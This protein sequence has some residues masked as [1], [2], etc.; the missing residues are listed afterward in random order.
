MSQSLA[1]AFLVGRQGGQG[2]HRLSWGRL[3]WGNCGG[4]AVSFSDDPQLGTGNGGRGR[5]GTKH[6]DQWNDRICLPVPPQSRENGPPGFRSLLRILTQ[7]R[8]LIWMDLLPVRG[9]VGHAL[10][11]MIRL[12]FQSSLLPHHDPIAV[13]EIITIRRGP[14]P[15]RSGPVVKWVHDRNGGLVR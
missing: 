9:L 4:T 3:D 2:A 10:M 6:V 14:V 11:L 8:P 12:R 1:T 15:V 5:P 13:V 7:T